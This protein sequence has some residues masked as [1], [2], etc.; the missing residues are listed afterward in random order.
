MIISILNQKGGS[1]KTTIATNLAYALL[2]KNKKVLIADSDPQGSARDWSNVKN[3][4]ILTVL[5]LDRPS[6]AKDITTIKDNYDHIIIDGAPQLSTHTAAA[7]KSSDIIL[8]PVMPSPYDLW[9]IADLVEAIKTKQEMG[10]KLKAYIL[11]SRAVKNTKIAAEIK[12]VV[13]E[14]GLPLLNSFTTQRVSYPDS[15]AKGLTIF[16]TQDKNAQLEINAIIKE[17]DLWI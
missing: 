14:Y 6:L 12:D 11:I 4:E 15:A 16:H 10:S 3:G 9:A 13:V 8:I 17:L 7:I 1:G 5:G 2:L